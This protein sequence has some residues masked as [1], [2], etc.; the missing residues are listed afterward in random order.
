MIQMNPSLR[1]AGWL[2]AF[3]VVVA[4]AVPWFLWGNSQLIGG[5]PLWLWWHIG[6]MI[7]ATAVFAAFT[8]H[9]WDR[10]LGGVDV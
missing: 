2:L 8:S 9:G 5:L 3:A 10:Y 4:G 6:W 1:A 7:V